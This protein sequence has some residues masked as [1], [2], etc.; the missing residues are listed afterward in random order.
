VS[1]APERPRRRLVRLVVVPAALFV[2]VSATAFALAKAHPAKPQLKVD[3]TKAVAL[4]NA[5]HGT[6]VFAQTC[7]GCH[8]QG[9]K[10]GGIGPKLAG[11]TISL[12]A[13]KAQIDGGGGTMPAGL[14]KGSDEED[15]L[16]YL[17]TIFAGQ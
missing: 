10:G 2:A 17:K 15:V 1:A 9:G 3:T 7:A 6:S 12:A 11:A 13:A 5:A 14:V 4:G 8:G 16:A